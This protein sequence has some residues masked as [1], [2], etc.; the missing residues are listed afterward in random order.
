MTSDYYQLLGVDKSAS[1]DE[2]KS[3][4]RRLARELHPDASG[5]DAESEARF[6]EVTTAYETLRDPERRRR[7]DMFGPDGARGAGAPGGEG[8]GFSGGLGDLFDAFFGGQGGFAQGGGRP[9]RRQ[10]S[11]AEISLRLALEQAVFGTRHEVHLKAPVACTT[12]D[13]TG[14]Q[15]GTS[16]TACGECRGSGQIQ[17][18][19]QSILGQMVTATVCPRCSGLGEIVASPCTDCRGE[20]RRVEDRTFTVEVPAGVDDGATLRVPGAG[21]APIR[22]G[23]PG[24]LYVHVQV[25]P[26]PRFERNG[27]DLVTTCHL[28]VAQ[29]ALGTEVDLDT[30]D[31]PYTLTIPS[32]SQTGRVL[33]VAGHG[34]P[35]LRSG[36][37]GDL[38]VQLFVDTPTKLSKEEDELLRKLAELRGETVS[39]PDSGL[40]SRLRSAFG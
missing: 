26:D 10:G 33:K 7:Y 32:G 19:R 29:A 36:R 13:A 37:R 17:R 5:G 30:L 11:D 23:T 8:F 35:R 27:N 24:D 39:P 16:A 6:K 18:V 34:V 40:L 1:E 9:G 28:S 14:A 22:G 25:A 4:Y 3:A 12:C 21:A 15:P 31:G 38:L 2:L 20:G